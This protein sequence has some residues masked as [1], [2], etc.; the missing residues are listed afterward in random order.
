MS[1]QMKPKHKSIQRKLMTVI[2]VTTGAVLLLT[3]TV[4]FIYEYVTY[5]DIKKTQLAT[6]GEIVAANSTAALAFDNKEDAAEILQALKAEKHIVAACLFDNEGHLFSAYPNQISISNFPDTIGTDGYSFKD[7]YLQGF[8]PVIQNEKRLGTLYLKTD[9]TDLYNRFR[10]YGLIALIF[11]S[12]AFLFAWFLSKLLQKRITKPILKLAETARIISDQG[13]Y[14]V[15]ASGG[16]NDE[17]GLLKDS[18]NQMLSQIE[19]QNEEITSLNQNL[20]KKV[21]ERTGQLENANTILVQ[22]NEFVETIID[23]S[24]DFI[25]V[26]DNELRYLSLNKNAIEGYKIR[27]EEIIGKKILEIFPQLAGSAMIEGLKKGLDGQMIHD[28]GYRSSVLNRHFENFFIPLKNK[29]NIVDRV[30][31]VAHDL[32][33]II[34]ANEK[35]K[36]LNTELEKSNR[37]LEQFAYVASHDL[38]EPLRKIQTFAELSERNINKPEILKRYLEKIGSSGLRMTDLIKAVL[39]YSRL[40]VVTNEFAAIDLNIVVQN[41]KTDLELLIQEK[42]AIIKTTQL[43]QISGIPLQ[44]HQLFFNLVTNSLKFSETRPEITISANIISGIELKKYPTLKN[45]GNYLKLSFEDNGIGFDEQYADKIFSI[46]QRLHYGNQ[47]SGTGIGL[48]L[49]KKIVE[50]HGGAITVK[51]EPG[52]GTTFYI[53]LPV[54]YNMVNNGR[55]TEKNKITS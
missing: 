43:P 48:A 29:D 14:S 27:K 18:F 46:F 22:Q 5:R 32:T 25:A 50:N 23:S 53:Y 39:N 41:I 47:Y 52:K 36:S 16:S 31:V 34:S 42:K 21:K 1:Y 7:G 30:L 37:D 19:A 55:P 38:Q 28:P 33:D 12:I 2:L 6:L 10:L 11:I 20:E 54:A 45:E 3:C 49:C 15:R 8:Q 26:F 9:L 24:V 13:D 35:L 40:S 4:F 44:I 17:V 51:S